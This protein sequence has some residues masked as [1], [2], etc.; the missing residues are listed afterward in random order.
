MSDLDPQ[1]GHL[2]LYRGRSLH[3]STPEYDDASRAVHMDAAGAYLTR[4][5]FLVLSRELLVDPINQPG[6][7]VRV[8]VEPLVDARA[9]ATA[10]S[11]SPLSNGDLPFG[12]GLVL[13]VE[14]GGGVF[15][16]ITGNSIWRRSAAGTWTQV[17]E[18]TD[19]SRIQF[20]RLRYGNGVWL[21]LQGGSPS[22][23]GY[24]LRSTDGGDNWTDVQV[25]TAGVFSFVERGPGNSWILGGRNATQV[26]TMRST[27]GGQT[28]IDGAVRSWTDGLM[29]AVY[30]DNRDV[31]VV[32]T[33]G[34]ALA[35]VFIAHP[36]N[37]FWMVFHDW[38]VPGWSV[39]DPAQ[40]NY[41]THPGAFR[42]VQTN[43]G[44]MVVV[45]SDGRVSYTGTGVTSEAADP[46]GNRINKIA[47]MSSE[48]GDVGIWDLAYDPIGNVV[49]AVGQVNVAGE[50][51]SPRA[52][53]SSDEGVTWE[54]MPDVEEAVDGPIYTVAV[55]DDGNALYLSD[56]RWA[57]SGTTRGL[58]GGEYNVYVVSYFNTHAGKFVYDMH[59]TTV[60]TED[61]GSIAFT[62]PNRQYI[63]QQNP[64]ISTGGWEPILDDLRFDVYVQAVREPIA[65]EDVAYTIRY[66]FTEPFPNPV[67]EGTGDP[68]PPD[69]SVDI[70]RTLEEL[71]LGRQLI[72]FGLPTTAVWEKRHTAL[73]N[74]RVW[75]MAA[76]DESR[77]SMPGDTASPEIANQSQRFVLSYTE[78]GWANLIG[79]RNWIVIQPTQS[80]RFT[81]MLSTPSGLLVMFE[82]EIH[83]VTGDPAF[84]NVS[85]ELYLDMVGHDP[86]LNDS[87]PGPQPCKVGG[88]PFVI[89]NGKVWVLQAGQAQQVGQ[90]QWLRDD[91]FRRISPE[92][93]T[94]SLLALTD[95]GQVFR[96][97]LD[98]QF[99]LTDPVTRDDTPV[100]ELLTNCACESG[101]NTRFMAEVMIG[102]EEWLGLWSTRTDGTPDAPHVYYRDLDFGALDSR[103]ALYLVKVGLEGDILT[104]EFDRNAIGFDPALLPALFY[105]AANEANGVLGSVDPL[106]A[107]GLIPYIRQNNRRSNTIAWRLPLARTRGSSIDVRLEL[108]GFDYNDVLKLPLQLFF[109][110]GGVV[111]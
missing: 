71:P 91:P 104:A 60:T 84:G 43:S 56:S 74:G 64:W 83:L 79:D 42:V 70:D 25:A 59:M 77:W 38:A 65:G 92:P 102:S 76:Q 99:W 28:W 62:A 101:D 109:A 18:E 51:I 103:S 108:R 46:T 87:D 105:E 19:P 90:E 5:K 67:D 37:D 96:Y 78:I 30:F 48:A 1:P 61:G 100:L 10:G 35:D 27:D 52:W 44:R 47:A 11:G 32:S 54:R 7:T 95:S 55:D 106:A 20:R 63:L 69:D 72:N 41:R 85:V 15:M 49:I 22:E 45:S 73:H 6:E 75:G 86:P 34:G 36:P 107:G 81:G 39:G 111:R 93:Q 13:E 14:F 24:V 53:R 80:T 21:V 3:T 2:R 68:L 50:G 57:F 82:N 98:D 26:W 94:R 58:E 17:Y 88:V 29:D 16:A 110:R 8:P 23:A 66:A 97:M 89:W 33:N 31:F 12:W 9:S 4:D 40:N